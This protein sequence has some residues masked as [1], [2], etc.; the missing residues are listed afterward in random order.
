[1]TDVTIITGGGRGIG[2]AIALRT[3]KD[4]AVIIVG[5]TYKDLKATS[6]TITAQGGQCALL[7]GSVTEEANAYAAVSL[8]KER[9]WQIRNLVCNAGIGISGA[10]ETFDFAL[11]QRIFDVNVNGAF[12]FAQ[13]CIPEMLTKGGGS[14]V[15]MSSIA[16]LNGVPY[17]SAYSASKHAL[18][19]LAHSLQAEYRKRGISVTPT[20]FGYVESEMTE[21]TIRGL[22]ERRG[23]S[24]ADARAK[25]GNILTA[26]EVADDVAFICARDTK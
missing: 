16:A 6:D 5:R 14:I 20:C 10:F 12:H 13:A 2:R 9:E 25:L 22:M 7:V 17:D 1:M 3:A 4:T 23:L 15:F 26:E 18:N 11:W 19:G 8:A 21:R 24:Y